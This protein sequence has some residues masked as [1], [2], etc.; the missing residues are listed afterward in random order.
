[1]TSRLLTMCMLALSAT[2]ASAQHINSHLNSRLTQTDVQGFY[3]MPAAVA[4]DY[5]DGTSSRARVRRHMRV[6][7][8]VGAKY[9][10][11]AFTW[12]AIEPQRGQYKWAFWDMLVEEAERADIQLIPYV[13]YTPEWAAGNP[14]Q[15]W[16]RPPTDPKLYAEFMYAIASR[17]RGRIHSWEIWN[18]PDITEYWMGDVDGFAEMVKLAAASIRRA[19]PDVTLVLGGMSKGPSVFFRQLVEKHHVERYVDVVA[20]HG[21]PESWLEERAETVGQSWTSEMNR[22][23]ANDGSRRDFWL[24]EIGYADYRYS[25]TE[26]NKYGVSAPFPHEHTPEFAASSLFKAQVMALASGQVSLTAWYRIDDFDPNTTTFSDD[27]V[28]FHLGLLDANRHPKPTYFALK[29]FNEVF[30][31]PT[32]PVLAPVLSSAGTRSNAVVNVF[33]QQDGRIVVVG[34]LRSL[35]RNEAP[36]ADGVKSDAR[37]EEVAVHLPCATTS[38]V[39]VTDPQGR[40][41]SAFTT[42]YHGWLGGLQLRPDRIFIAEMNCSPAQVRFTRLLR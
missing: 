13:A 18:E 10:R 22:L 4:D 36:K 40:S 16:K 41:T 23:V 17:Y 12:N 21:Y 37:R 14:D 28:N 1:M 6:A 31:Q 32:R 19:A 2:V 27:H 29:H 20:M 34:W 7:R 30:A 3:R 25:P 15:F 38:N 9:L 33:E 8:N 35:N 5:F 26:A 24:N 39:N 11:C 42:F